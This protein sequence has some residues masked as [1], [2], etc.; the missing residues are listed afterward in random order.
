MKLVVD[1]FNQEKALVGAFSMIVKNDGS[2]AALVSTGAGVRGH[3]GLRTT[4]GTRAAPTH[5]RHLLR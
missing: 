2:F 4:A 1:T 3:S 5:R